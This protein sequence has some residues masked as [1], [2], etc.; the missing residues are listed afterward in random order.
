VSLFVL[1][2]HGGGGGRA[3]GCPHPQLYCSAIHGHWHW[4]T[5]TLGQW[6]TGTGAVAHWG[7]GALVHARMIRVLF[8]F[9]MG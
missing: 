2:M 8:K 1:R 7:S 3:G 4:G 6:R 9:I 5:V